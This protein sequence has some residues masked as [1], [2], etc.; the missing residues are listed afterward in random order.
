MVEGFWNAQVEQSTEHPA[1]AFITELFGQPGEELQ[2][3]EELGHAE[4][5][6]AQAS[7]PSRERLALE[8]EAHSK[9]SKSKELNRLFDDMDSFERR[10]RTAGLSDQQ[11]ADTYTQTT[12]LLSTTTSTFSLEQRTKIAE[13]VIR[14]AAR[15]TG[16]DQGRHGT[17]NVAVVESRLY[18]KTPEAAAKLV[19]DIATTGSFTTQDGSIITPTGRSLTPDDEAG[20]NP[21]GDGK[22][23][24]A[25][26]IFQ[27]TAANVH[28]QRMHVTP[29]GVLSRRGAITYEQIPSKRSSFSGD[30][31]ERVLDY[32]VNPPRETTKYKQG[33][34]LSVSDL[35]GISNQITGKAESGF[36]I[37]NKVFGGNGTV[38]V[39][40][41][42]ELEQAINDARQN[43]KLPAFIRVHTGNEPFLSDSGG[44]FT[45]QRGVWHVVSITNFD[46]R[47][48]K[49]TI[50]NQWG[51]RGD[52]TIDLDKLYKATLEPG[53]PEWKKKHEAYILP[54]VGRGEP[55]DPVGS[56][57]LRNRIPRF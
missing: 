16:I 19:A 50:D 11:I 8:T 4:I 37:E 48:K 22:R 17:C 23:G 32:S 36:V 12:R 21:P 18:A 15:P 47:T 7:P 45:R 1:P 31:G 42:R 53:T 54:G 6:L 39:T 3:G 14:N 40:S 44:A 5:L 27:V 41:P 38:H 46:A 20:S 10:A 57:D 35:I 25:S 52:K 29:D 13:Q 26:Q 28:W 2:A 49:V 43:G 33:P 9:I 56:F 34:S 24:L 55:E 51:S 30:T